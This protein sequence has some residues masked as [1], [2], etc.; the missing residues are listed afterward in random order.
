MP[1][2]NRVTK[3]VNRNN[4]TAKEFIP[5]LKKQDATFWHLD[6]P[7]LEGQQLQALFAGLYLSG[8]EQGP[9]WI[10]SDKY[11][12][13]PLERAD[14]QEHVSPDFRGA[15]M[16]RSNKRLRGAMG[17]VEVLDSGSE[18]EDDE[19]IDAFQKC[20]N[21]RKPN[22][23]QGLFHKQRDNFLC[24]HC[25]AVSS[26]HRRRSG[27]TSVSSF[28]LGSQANDAE[29]IQNRCESGSPL[30]LAKSSTPKAIFPSVTELPPFLGLQTPETQSC[31]RAIK[32]D[33]M[34]IPLSF[35][36]DANQD[37]SR[38]EPSPV[39]LGNNISSPRSLVEQSREEIALKPS[40]LNPQPVVSEKKNLRKEID[41]TD[42]ASN[43]NKSKEEGDCE[44]QGIDLSI[45]SCVATFRIG[46]YCGRA[47]NHDALFLTLLDQ[48]W[49][50]SQLIGPVKAFLF[51]AMKAK[52]ESV[53]GDVDAVLPSFQDSDFPLEHTLKLITISKISTCAKEDKIRAE[54]AQVRCDFELHNLVEKAGL[55][56][57]P[58]VNLKKGHPV[59]IRKA[60][61][62]EKLA[63]MNFSRAG[64]NLATC[65]E[66]DLKPFLDDCRKQKRVGAKAF[67]PFLVELSNDLDIEA[68]LKELDSQDLHPEGFEDSRD[69]QYSGDS[70]KMEELFQEFPG[71]SSV[72][73]AGKSSNPG[74]NILLEDLQRFA[75]GSWLSDTVVDAV[76]HLYREKKPKDL[77]LLRSSNLETFNNKPKEDQEG[78]CKMYI[79]SIKGPGLYGGR[80]HFGRDYRLFQSI[81]IYPISIL[82][83]RVL[84]VKA[85]ASHWT[86]QLAQITT[87]AGLEATVLITIKVWDSL[88]NG[89]TP[90]LDSKDG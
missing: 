22:F 76:M 77:Y 25:Q 78:L 24:T 70:D 50:T 32:L 26:F 27:T 15:K 5:F 54:I 33:P 48:K 60:M 12:E 18:K 57:D 42:E 71:T 73:F 63:K 37:I 39:E 84:C 65:T 46:K 43:K 72:F 4:P 41:L 9:K 89:H 30:L 80:G 79:D 74:L 81:Y 58:T 53:T 83:Y 7:P 6:M 17:E 38:G 14:D 11:N 34:P 69:Q 66:K 16:E 47:I 90:T 87:P 35:D 61:Y 31:E 2:I 59:D 68:L 64:G 82:N 19:I 1:S 20:T 88:E 36:Q 52:S 13:T 28:S 3:F 21:C 10:L 49:E 23:A 45:R 55:A 51:K 8:E 67:E 40:S 44:S 85:F 86:T 62:Y 56:V 75:E 29:P